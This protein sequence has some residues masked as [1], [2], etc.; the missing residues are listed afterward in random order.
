MNKVLSGKVLYL[1]RM[2]GSSLHELV[3]Y[4][5]IK[6]FCLSVPLYSVSKMKI[7]HFFSILI[8]I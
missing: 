7:D 5:S 1:S 8:Y 4:G 2:D 6:I 3:N